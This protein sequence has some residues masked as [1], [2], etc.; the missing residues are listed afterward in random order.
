M[1]PSDFVPH[2]CYEVFFEKDI[3]IEFKYLK[4]TE[5]GEIKS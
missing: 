5:T 3:P 1:E 2:K 4:T